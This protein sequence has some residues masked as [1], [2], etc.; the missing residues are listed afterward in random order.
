MD[1]F[2]TIAEVWEDIKGYEN[3]YKI[4]NRG[5]V[6]SVR[7]GRI[8][9]PEITKSGYAR[10]GLAV[11]NS[12]VKKYV[13]RLVAEAFIPNKNYKNQVNHID[14]NKLN[15]F[16]SNL[17]WVTSKENNIHRIKGYGKIDY[18]KEVINST[19]ESIIKYLYSRTDCTHNDLAV[20]F[21]VSAATI[22]NICRK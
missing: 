8:I 20:I 10:I 7:F 1:N 14:G 3:Y 5:S 17:E 11:D 12:R 15:N 21:N 9:K 22:S 6:L 16:L 19:D 18:E 4:S 2:N 13:H